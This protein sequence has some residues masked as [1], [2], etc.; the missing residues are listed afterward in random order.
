MV[1]LQTY[2][3]QNQH[4]VRVLQA[5]CCILLLSQPNQMVQNK[6]LCMCTEITDLH[7]NCTKRWALRWL[8]WQ[9]LN[10]QKS[11][12]TCCASIH[13]THSIENFSHCLYEDRNHFTRRQ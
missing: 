11:K 12:L 9:A 13:K 10:C 4:V 7:R 6:Y 5:T 8:K 3:L 1:T 2:V